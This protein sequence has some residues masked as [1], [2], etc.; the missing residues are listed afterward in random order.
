MKTKK[1][2]QKGFTLIEALVATALFATTIVAIVGVYLSTVTINRRTDVIRTASENARY[3]SEYLSK[4]IRN[5]QIDYYGPVKSPCSSTLTASSSSLAIVNIE[6]DHLCFYLGDANGQISSAG[7]NLWL[8]KNNFA[9][10]KVNSSNVSIKNLIFYVSPIINPYA[11]GS[12]VQ[13]RVTFT[14]NVQSTS[15]SQ[16]NI[17]IPIESSVTIPSYDI[18]AP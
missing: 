7:T 17:I 2:L 1:S 16:D 18:A 12:T 11:A 3:L 10:S 15:G 4:E 8:I 9:A 13:P 6:G 14:A 5:G